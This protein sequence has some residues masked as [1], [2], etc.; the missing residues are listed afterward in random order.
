MAADEVSKTVT[1]LFN[2]FAREG[3]AALAQAAELHGA[4]VRSLAAAGSSYAGVEAANLSTLTA[5][6][7]GGT[8]ALTGAVAAGPYVTLVM[9][10]S[11]TPI[12]PA[13]FVANVVS[14]YVTPNFPAGLVQALFLPAGEYPDSGIKDLTSDVSIARGVQ[15]L[16][17]TIAHNW[18]PETP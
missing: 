17:T 10:G 12:P 14:R 15:I 2:A 1:G 16:T 6:L 13:D 3:Q 9:G 7:T 11:G 5:P 8:S 18:R 4:F